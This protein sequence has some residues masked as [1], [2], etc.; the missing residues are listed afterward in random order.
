MSPKTTDQLHQ[1]KSILSLGLSQDDARAGLD[2][3]YMQGITDPVI[4]L[5]DDMNGYMDIPALDDCHEYQLREKYRDM[6][7]A[8][9][10]QLLS[11]NID[12]ALQGIKEEPIYEIVTTHIKVNKVKIRV[13]KLLDGDWDE[14]L[15][16]NFDDPLKLYGRYVLGGHALYNKI[17]EIPFAPAIAEAKDETVLRELLKKF[18]PFR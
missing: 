13:R 10:S 7:K 3:I 9:V 12:N 16:Q 2:Q 15:Y 17:V 8:E 1:L 11:K 14:T 6:S 4:T 5:R 18:K